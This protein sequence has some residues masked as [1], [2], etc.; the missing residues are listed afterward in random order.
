MPRF[1]DG[2]GIVRYAIFVTLTLIL[3]VV[4]DT[5]ARIIGAVMALVFI[6]PWIPHV[7]GRHGAR[8]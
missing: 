8:S 1:F 5:T 7:M 2:L 4:G 3:L 6:G